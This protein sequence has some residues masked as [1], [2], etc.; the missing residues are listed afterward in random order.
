MGGFGSTRW[1]S[2][3][4]S[5]TVEGARLLDINRLNR[6]GCL[7]P[8][9]WGGWEWKQDGQRVAWIQFR[10]DGSLFPHRPKG[11]HRRTY[12]RLQSAVLN[13]EILAEERIILFL[14]RLE[15]RELGSERR[16]HQAIG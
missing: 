11:M 4:T 2:T 1:G 9:Y 13:A 3:S 12:E 7:Q 14:G 5:N 6:M 8:G 10:R 15:H 16:M